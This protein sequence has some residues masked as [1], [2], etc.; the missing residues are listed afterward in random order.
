LKNSTDPPAAQ[1]EARTI[2]PDLHI[3]AYAPQEIARRVEKIGA[4]KARQDPW[5]TVALAVL[6]GAF[7]ALGAQFYTVVVHDSPFG[8]GLTQFVGG[9]A[10]TLGLILVVIAGA[11]LFTGNTLIVMAFVQRKIT[12]REVL[13]NWA[14]VY[15]GNFLGALG[16]VLLVYATRQYAINEGLVGAKALAIAHTK[17]NY[18]FLVAFS[19]GILCNALVTLAVWLSISGR[20]VVDK[21]AAMLLPIAAFVASGFEHSVAN[22]YLIPIGMLLKGHPDLVALAAKSIGAPLDLASLSFSGLFRNLVP[23][24]L[25]N[26]VGGAFLVGLTY[27]FIYLR[28]PGAL[29]LPRLFPGTAPILRPAKKPYRPKEKP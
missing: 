18:P 25:G 1:G 12:A 10:F 24:T 15:F 6:A 13:R 26:I 5:T 8:V 19:R 27:W 23:V 9:L 28:Q 17:V 21:I 7:I 22:M 16:I 3:E 11:E 29:R 20:Y 2:P 14:L 4:T